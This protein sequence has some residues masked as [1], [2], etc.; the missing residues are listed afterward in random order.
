M[1]LGQVALGL[2]SIALG[3]RQLSNGVQRLGYASN[4][5]GSQR[6]S[7]TSARTYGKGSKRTYDVGSGL[8]RART[9]SGDIRLRTYQIKNL[10]ERVA[11]LRRLVE[12]GKRDPVV[13]EFA[14]RA[15]NQKCGPRWCVPEKDNLAEIKA[16]F[17]AVRSNVRY[18]S[19]IAGIDSYQA[20][21]HTL[22]LRSA[23]CDDVSILACAL[24][25]SIGLPCRFKV[26]RT[27]G[28]PEWNHIYAQV[29]HPRRNPKRWISFDASVDMPVGWEAPS[30]MVDASRIFPT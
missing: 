29:G 6:A 15:V 23:D 12:Q 27:K 7:R 26:I 14:R 25:Q 30:R 2:A 19:D 9:P 8:E 20:P 21:R 5:T 10:D 3:L 24:A 22:K 4:P 11:H 16:L 28:S 18:T 17:R 13:Y 1:S